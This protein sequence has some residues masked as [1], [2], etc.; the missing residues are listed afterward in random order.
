MKRQPYYVSVQQRTV[1]TD[2]TSGRYEFI[3][4]ATGAER[5]HLQALIDD[6]GDAETDAFRNYFTLIMRQSNEEINM[7]Y[8]QRVHAVYMYIHKLGN[9]DTKRFVEQMFDRQS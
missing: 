2:P 5:E 1:V 8:Q 7:S 9:A 4:E 6:L 3:V